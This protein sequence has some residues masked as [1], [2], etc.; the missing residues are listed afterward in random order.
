W[1]PQGPTETLFVQTMVDTHWRLNN[2]RSHEL[3]TYAMHHGES[4]EPLSEHPEV[5][6]ALAASEVLSS[7]TDELKLISLYEQR[8]TRTLEKALAQL[9]ALQ[10]ERKEREAREMR[11]ATRI[12]SMFQM[13]EKPYKPEDSGFVFS[14]ERLE[15]WQVRQMHLVN[16]KMAEEVNF[17]REKFLQ[18]LARA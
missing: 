6:A 4:D 17:N 11:D 13:L 12:Q 9:Q 8:L 7:K 1:C 10:A 16:A 14:S 18:R 2:M 5:D 15:Q 3:C